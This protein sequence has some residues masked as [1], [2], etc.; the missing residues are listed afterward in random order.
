MCLILFKYDPTGEYPLTVLANRDE[1]HHRPTRQAGFWDDHPHILAGKDLEKGGTWMGVTTGGR[2]AAVTNFRSRKDMQ[3]GGNSRGE[4]PLEFL[5]GSMST[6]NYLAATM[7]R[8]GDF[9]GFN[10]LVFDG[11]E[12]GYASNRSPQPAGIVGAGIH[13][14]SNAL[15]DTPWPKVTE[16]KAALADVSARATPDPSWLSIMA[17][18]RRAPLEQLPD[19]GIGEEKEYLLSSRCIEMES[20]GTRCSSFVGLRRD[21][22]VHFLEKT[23][24]PSDSDPETVRFII[25]PSHPGQGIQAG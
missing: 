17:D 14:L 1:F 9:A 2:F 11:K 10:L 13:G 24:V 6:M 18:T 25:E 5:K 8:G 15:L 23:L 7:E 22:Q 20:Y 16:G 12:L 19:T 4:L 3:A 21:G